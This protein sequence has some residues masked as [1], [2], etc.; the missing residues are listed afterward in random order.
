MKD[1]MIGGDLAK[2]VFQVHGAFCAGEVQFR[3][4]FGAARFLRIS[5]TAQELT[6]SRLSDVALLGEVAASL[7][8][9]QVR[10]P[11]PESDRTP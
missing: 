4:M 2:N 1:M 8:G 10:P 9:R 7:V 3:K 11:K 5:A 6:G